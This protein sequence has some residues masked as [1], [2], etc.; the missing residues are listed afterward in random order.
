MVKEWM[1]HVN[2]I[3]MNR[4]K[5]ILE[6]KG[7]K[8]TWLA[9][10][11]GKSYNMV[12]SYAQNRRQPSLNILL[13]IASILDVEA[14]EL[15]DNTKAENGNIQYSGHLHSKQTVNEPESSYTKTVKIPVLGNVSCGLPF[16][17]EENIE[18]YIPVSD[19]FMKTSYHYF[20]LR[21][22]GDSMDDAGINDGDLVLIRQQQTA[23]NG[24]RVVALID[25]EATIKE[26]YHKGNMIVLK[27]RS[28]NSKHQPI[29]LTED[30][31]IQGV[32]ESVI[33]I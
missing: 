30:F 33:P 22:S 27:P 8:Q 32:V 3:H 10:R 20:I 25:N 15:I 11:L 19:R 23:Y 31:R 12:N 9:E 16:L 4:I 13:K 17:A 6:E 28:K 18:T 14:N 29:I 2:V 26:F 5:E 24:D 1:L 7:V 21:A